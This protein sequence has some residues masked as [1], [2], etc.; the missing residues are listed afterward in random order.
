MHDIP[1]RLRG[2]G[3]G[4]NERPLPHIDAATYKTNYQA[5]IT[6]PDGEY[7]LCAGCPLQIVVVL[8]Y[9]R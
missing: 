8:W 1:L 2:K 3:E 5:S 6:N 7:A 9:L 4:R